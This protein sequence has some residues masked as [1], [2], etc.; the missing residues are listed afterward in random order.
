MFVTTDEVPPS[1]LPVVL[2]ADATSKSVQR[3]Q[4]SPDLADR[5]LDLYAA[6]KNLIEISK[7]A[8]MPGY[9]TLQKWITSHPEFSRRFQA[10]GT[11]LALHRE[12]QAI[13]TAEAA[14]GKDADRLKIETY[15]RS[16]EVNDPARYGKKV[17]HGGDQNNPVILQVITGFGPP[18]AWQSPPKLNPDGTIMKAAE[19]IENGKGSAPDESHPAAL[20][21][22]DGGGIETLRGPAEPLLQDGSPDTP[23]G[24]GSD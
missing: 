11:M 8:E 15:W 9:S 6:G 18:N 3:V 20:C 21:L 13:Q 14:E 1:F 4:Y 22:P 10:V 23:V 7:M 24:G 5:I 16:A 2:G 12:Q 19:V 17:T